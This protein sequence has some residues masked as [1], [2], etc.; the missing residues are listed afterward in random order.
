MSYKHVRNRGFT[1]IECV[2]SILVLGGL[3]VAGLQAVGVSTDMRASAAEDARA[4]AMAESMLSE[5]LSNYVG[6]PS[7][8]LIGGLVSGT[9]G[10]DLG[11]VKTQKQT[12][13]DIDDFSG[14]TES[15]PQFADGINISGYSGWTRAVLVENVDVAN[16]EN[17][18][19]TRTGLVRV[20]VT[21]TTRR[22]KSVQVA[23]LRADTMQSYYKVPNGHLPSDLS[24]VNVGELP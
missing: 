7:S 21:V 20:T 1:L 18:S 19:I 6:E 23:A 3:L 16:P 12:F 8:S 11:E 4:A 24:Y 13:D 15:P 2:V 9:L 10:V 17:V 14:W 22:G 5:V